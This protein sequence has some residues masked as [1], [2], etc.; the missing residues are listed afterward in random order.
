MPLI[1]YIGNRQECLGAN[2]GIGAAPGPPPLTFD[3]IIVGGGAA[4]SGGGVGGS[5]GGVLS[6]SAVTM[7]FNSSI[8][9]VVGAGGTSAGGL[10][11]TN[12]ASSSISGSTFGFV[13]A[14]GATGNSGAPS[15][16]SQGLS[17]PGLSQGG[18]A[19]SSKNGNAGV[20][21][22]NGDGGT[23]SVWVNGLYYAGGGGG[24]GGYPG[25]VNP[26]Y[27][28]LGGGGTAQTGFGPDDLPYQINGYNGRGGGAAGSGTA[29]GS[30]S[31]IIRYSTGS[32]V[33]PYD[34]TISGGT[35]EISGGYA[36]RTFTSSAELTYRY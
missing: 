10:P 33:P 3:F 15:V 27:P 32:L 22:Q 20:L 29:G 35:L 21:N 28:G 18:G 2:S 5:A 1:N 30:G 34:N 8:T 24:T 19:G 25:P 12:A 26:G 11:I 17:G 7:S 23:G 4:G 9:I 31:V 13:G 6:G 14:G 16:F 36:Y